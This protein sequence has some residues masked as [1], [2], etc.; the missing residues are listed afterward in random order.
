MIQAEI[1]NIGDELLIGQVINTNASFMA[2]Q[3][4]LAGIRVNRI[5]AIADTEEAIKNAINQAFERSDIVISTGG[6]GPTKDDITKKVLCEYFDDTLIMNQEVLEHVA[7]FFKNRNHALSEVNRQQAMVPSRSKIIYNQNG[8]APGIWFEKEGK[9]LISTPG[10]PFEMKAMLTDTI[11]PKLRDHYNIKTKICHRTILTSG[12]G[13]SV[14]AEKIESWSRNLGE[15]KLAFLPQPGIVR[16]R[17]SLISSDNAD[18]DKK[19]KE[20]ID[21]LYKL[22]PDLIFGE[23]TQTLEEICGTLLKTHNKSMS[24]AESCTGGYIS[25]LLTSIAGSSNYFK[26]NITSYSNTAKIELL[27]VSEL[28]LEKHGAVNKEV[29]EQMAQGARKALHSDYAIATSGIAGPGGGTE[30]KPVGTVWIAVSSSKQTISKRFQFG[31]HRGRNIRRSAV[32]ALNM[33]RKLIIEENK[34]FNNK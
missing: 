34:G 1:I 22:I 32:T 33:L 26:G 10:V 21:K 20:Q 15:I 30:E 24:T 7:T 29:V 16:L 18:A 2:E 31:E 27:G 23:E 19:I 25:H 6:L 5:T 17:L 12:V 11:I 3:L 28:E 14:L 8:T 13:E 9:V 4:N